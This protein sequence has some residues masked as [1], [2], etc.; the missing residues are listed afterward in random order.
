MVGWLWGRGSGCGTTSTLL[1]SLVCWT[2]SGA[3]IGSWARVRDGRGGRR[4]RGRVQGQRG[5]ASGCGLGAGSRLSS[6]VWLLQHPNKG[7][8]ACRM[9]GQSQRHPQRAVCR[10]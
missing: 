4:R 7:E 1:V 6:L 8:F 10:C 5:P 3:I 9:C 2:R